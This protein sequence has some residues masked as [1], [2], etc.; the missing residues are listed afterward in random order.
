MSG[1]KKKQACSTGRYMQL[2]VAAVATL[3]RVHLIERENA[4]ILD[5][6]RQLLPIVPLR[7]RVGDRHWLLTNLDVVPDAAGDCVT[8]RRP[9]MATGALVSQRE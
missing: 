7:K 9:Q 6:A 8:P 5:Q 3:A 4:P 1:E 2:A